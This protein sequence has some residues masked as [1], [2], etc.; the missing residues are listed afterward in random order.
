M[1]EILPIVIQGRPFVYPEIKSLAK[2]IK[3]VVIAIWKPIRWVLE[4]IFT[5]HPSQQ[6]IEE[7]RVRAMRLIGHF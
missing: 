3:V 1:Q 6:Y 5:Q 7:N 4:A 2:T